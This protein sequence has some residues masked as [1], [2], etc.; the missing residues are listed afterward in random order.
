MYYLLYNQQKYQQLQQDR[1]VDYIISQT[2][3]N[4]FLAYGKIIF[5]WF[6]L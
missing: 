5:A 6:S 1:Q 3:Q 2:N 4:L